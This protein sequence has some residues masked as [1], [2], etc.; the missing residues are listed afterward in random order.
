MSPSMAQRDTTCERA[1]GNVAG[2]FSRL[3]RY[4]IVPKVLTAKSAEGPRIT[5]SAPAQAEAR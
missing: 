1:H 4:K 5:E 3:V 2:T